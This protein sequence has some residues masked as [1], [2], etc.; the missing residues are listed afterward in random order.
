M[1]NERKKKEEKKERGKRDDR[2]SQGKLKP[3]N[4]ILFK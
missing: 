1:E 3:F 4:I 2:R